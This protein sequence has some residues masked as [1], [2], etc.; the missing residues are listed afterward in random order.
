MTP[1]ENEH[2]LYGPSA[3]HRRIAC[4]GSASAERGVPEETSEESADG[5]AHHA[6]LEQ[7]LL[8][9]GNA[10]AHV[11]KEFTYGE[12][13]IRIDR[14]RARVVQAV[15]DRV[16]EVNGTVYPEVRVSL[17]AWIPG[18]FG[19]S[20]I[21][22]RRPD[23][24]RIRDAKFGRGAIVLAKRNPQC[25][26]YAAGF[27]DSVLREDPDVDP[28]WLARLEAGEIPVLLEIDQPYRGNFDVWE[29]TL[30]EILRFAEEYVAVYHEAEQPDAPRT[31]GPSQCEY[32]KAKP[33]C[34]PFTDYCLDALGMST[35]DLDL[36][37][38]EIKQTRLNP[39][40]LTAEQRARLY[41]AKGLIT[42]LLDIT[43]ETLRHD[44]MAGKPTGGMKLIPGR[45]LRV[46]HDE[47]E[48]RAALTKRFKKEE[49]IKESLISPAK[50]LD[51]AGPRVVKK[52]EPLITTRES[53]PS[54]VPEDHKTPG[55]TRTVDVFDDLDADLDGFDM[56][57]DLD[58]FSL[59]L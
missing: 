14:D 17:A 26:L 34:K 15:A 51:L 21:A 28:D 56:A 45:S 22:I 37:L 52:I 18:Q 43:E 40:T 35:D 13:T 2:S 3:A 59:D 9:K 49:V 32:C 6:V 31:A 1:T 23:S 55:L 57:A 44:Y 16:D 27:W 30:P 38:D 29:T 53:K 54:I 19:T 12:H 39:D 20:D 33:T 4:R 8:G 41:Q 46:W 24:L 47:D 36:D 42:K 10:F 5:S 25:M 7:V 11:T 58:D 48:A 50:A